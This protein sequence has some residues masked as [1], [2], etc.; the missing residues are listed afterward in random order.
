MIGEAI[1]YINI[2]DSTMFSRVKEIFF[3]KLEN[4]YA[5]I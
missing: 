1:K 4:Q 5:S 3:S 2:T